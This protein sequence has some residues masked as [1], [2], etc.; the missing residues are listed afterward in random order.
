MSE[1][2]PYLAEIPEL[3]GLN[4][5]GEKLSADDIHMIS[6]ATQLEVLKIQKIKLDSNELKPLQAL[7]NLKILTISNAPKVDDNIFQT[8]AKLKIKELDLSGT[9]IDGSQIELLSDNDN[10]QILILGS[11]KF[12]DEATIKLLKMP[13]LQQLKLSDTKITENGIKNLLG[14]LNLTTFWAPDLPAATQIEF[15]KIAI[16]HRKKARAAG[17]STAPYNLAPYASALEE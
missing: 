7:K 17:Q 2:L 4:C 11:T 3:R 10:L 6:N 15:A 16:E 13:Q 8:I 12:T 1:I 9:G 14:M 5:G